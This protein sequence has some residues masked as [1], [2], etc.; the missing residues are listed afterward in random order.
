MI[1]LYHFKHNLKNITK[2]LN[3][4]TVIL[5]TIGLAT[6]GI[7]QSQNESDYGYYDS[8]NFGVGYS[9]SFGS[10]NDRNFHILDLD[11]NKTRYGGRH[12]GGFQYGIGTAIGLNTEKFTIGP[13][14]NGTLYYQFLAFGMELITYTDF[15]NL[16]LRCVPFFGIGGE[17]FKLTINPHLILTNKNFQP[18]NKGLVNLSVNLSLDRKKIK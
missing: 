10:P 15:E 18:V 6:S 17:K 9:Y 3:L 4:R 7:G 5:L 14:I 13:K 16:T 8:L 2:K 11:I 1:K 12:G